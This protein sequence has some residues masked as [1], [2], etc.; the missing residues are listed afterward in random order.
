VSATLR[1]RVAQSDAA[2][3]DRFWAND[4]IDVLLSD[5]SALFDELICELWN[6]QIPQGARSSMALFAVGGYGRAEL[7]PGSDIDLL[8]LITRRSSYQRELEGF[9]QSLWDLGVEIG[10][11]VRTLRECGREA[12]ADIT[13]ATALYERRLLTGPAALAAKLDKILSS[14]RLWPTPRFFAAK[15][16]EQIERHENFENIEYGLEPNLK[17]SPGGLR[18]IHTVLW[19][20]RR[21]FGTA[22]VS[23]LLAQSVLTEQEIDWLV[24]GK[25]FLSWVRFGLHLIAGRKDDRLQFEYQ[26][27]LAQRFGYVDTDAKRGVER[28]MQHYYRHVLALRELNDIVLQIFEENILVRGRKRRWPKVEQINDRFRIRNDYIETTAEDVFANEP[29]ALLEMFVVMANR[30]DVAGVRAST[31]RSIRDHLHLIDDEFRADPKVTDLFLQLLRAPYTLVSQLTRLRRYGILGRYLPEFGA[32]IGQMQ[33]DLFHIYT[34]DAHTMSVI[35]NMR[36]FRYRAANETYP[37]AHHCVKNLPKVELLYIAGLYHDIG[38]GRGGDHSELGAVDAA[39]FCARHQLT[40]KDTDL[41]CWLVRMHLS[42]SSIA[43]RKDIHDPEVVYEFAQ[44]MGTQE[45][46]DYL[47]ALTA[48]DITATN[49][50]LWNSWRASLLRTLYQETR[51]S[52]QR[53]LETATDRDGVIEERRNAI[54]ERLRDRD[55]TRAAIDDALALLNDDFFFRYSDVRGAELLAECARHDVRAGPLVIVRELLGQ[56]SGEN[57][58]EV[59]LYCVDQPGLFAASVAALASQRLAIFDATIHTTPDLRCLN[60]FVVLDDDGRSI[61]QD[62]QRRNAVKSALSQSL[63]KSKSPRAKPLTRL[64]RQTKQMVL[65]TT[66]ELRNYSGSSTSNLTIVT[67]DHS[68]LLAR[69]GA[70]FLELKISV[71]GARI[72]TLGSRVEDVFEITNEEGQRFTD[73]EEIY[74]LTNSIRQSVDQALASSLDRS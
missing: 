67:S 3:A 66:A 31:I 9:V 34:V 12:K 60:A 64:P 16:A 47:Y 27:E 37:I 35:R 73:A 50:T 5:R 56:V 44:Q 22:Q 71:K 24:E 29:K 68:G 14:Q 40:E 30:R 57:V 41:V 63:V 51:N 33:H 15:L 49:P 26:R 61:G 53:G 28:F 17:N 11:S 70:I 6:T 4:D 10:Q 58:T 8:I 36:R 19:I 2:L 45:R 72:T 7:H 21:E 39:E 48:A 43:Q 62:V 32:I 23:E 74:Q 25:R 46:L 59:V 52:L 1:E 38:K 54:T 42:M 13:I 55:L 69:L 18:D 20:L 65:P